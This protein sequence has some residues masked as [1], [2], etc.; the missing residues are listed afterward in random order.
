LK[1]DE[2]SFRLGY[3]LAMETDIGGMRENQD[4][5]FIW[6]HQESNSVVLAVLDGHG[7]DLGAFA[8]QQARLAMIAWLEEHFERVLDSPG[9]ALRELFA[10]T[11]QR[12]FEAYQVVL[13][14]GGWEVEAQ[15]GYLVKRRGGAGAAWACVHG[16]S[17]CS[18]VVLA[19]GGRRMWTANVGDS[20]GVLSVNGKQVAPAML[21]PLYSEEEP[22]PEETR[23]TE[24]MLP[25]APAAVV[26]ITWDHSPECPREFRRLRAKKPDEQDPRRP[27]LLVVYDSPSRKKFQCPN[28]FE[29]DR[30]GTPVVT[31]QGKYYKNVRRE[32]ASLITTP[33][34]ARFHDALAFTRSL[35]DFHLQACGITC[36]PDVFEFDLEA[37][38]ASDEAPSGSI[39]ESNVGVICLCS[40]GVWDNWLYEE[41]SSFLLDS[42]RLAAVAGA[43]TAED[44]LKEF[45]ETNQQ[46]AHNHFGNDA[47]NAT[48]ILCYF[49]PQFA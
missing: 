7:S 26:E 28:V 42:A 4:D 32:W 45:M 21:R 27:H 33:P 40:D 47:D 1:A 44:A 10:H 41:V 19:R 37:V 22:E 8:S 20:S 43:D 23:F 17:S 2:S 15:H 11:Q 5:G 24:G 49:S 12:M 30:R 9:T 38:F 36:I 16:G 46:K 34:A 18:V 25:P 35:G 14:K 48:G 29:L 31:G 13:R 6:K 3:K 39:G